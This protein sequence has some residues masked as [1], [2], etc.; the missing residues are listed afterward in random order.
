MQCGPPGASQKEETCTIPPGAAYILT[1]VAQGRTNFCSMRK[2]A[3]NMCSCCWT[4][5]I[6]N[7]GSVHTRESITLRVFNTEWGREEE[8]I[9]E[10]VEVVAV[11]EEDS[12]DEGKPDADA[13]GKADAADAA[14]ADDDDAEAAGSSSAKTEEG[15]SV[16]MG[17]EAAAVEPLA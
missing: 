9:L 16:G 3:H 11:G 14:A 13:A 6:W 15:D 1:G 10:A 8:V 12:A 5:G 7:E 4:H 17:G 2:V